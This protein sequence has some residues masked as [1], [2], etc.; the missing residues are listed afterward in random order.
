MEFS[1]L[2]DLQ[3]DLIHLSFIQYKRLLFL[4]DKE[5]VYLLYNLK[6]YENLLQNYKFLIQ[7]FL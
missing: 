7:N 5:K 1:V 4:L 6:L 3:Q 2:I